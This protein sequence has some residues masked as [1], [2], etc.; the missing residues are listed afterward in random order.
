M[1]VHDPIET[2]ETHG[3]QGVRRMRRVLEL[4]AARRTVSRC[5]VC[6][7][8]EVRTDEVADRG[9][10][11]LAEC[12]HCD[13]RWTERLPDEAAARRPAASVRPRPEPDGGAA[14]PGAEVATAA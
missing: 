12:P 7:S 11:L 4:P 9:W 8:R 1:T 3:A 14:V 13:H 5:L 10:V 6:G 2:H